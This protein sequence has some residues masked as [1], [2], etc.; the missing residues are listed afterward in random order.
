[1]ATFCVGAVTGC[2]PNINPSIK[3]YTFGRKAFVTANSVSAMIE[4]LFMSG[5][6]I[7]LSIISDLTG[8]FTPAYVIH[9][10][11][12]AIFAVLL[13]TIKPMAP[14]VIGVE[15]A[16]EIVKRATEP[17]HKGS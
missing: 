7:F 8:S 4:N 14:E 16:K 3:A 15:A 13:L 12:T 1:M 11:I 6:L 10:I 17:R 5:A 2:F 9:V